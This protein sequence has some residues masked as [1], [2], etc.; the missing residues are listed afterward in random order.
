[1][2]MLTAIRTRERHER[3]AAA[4]SVEGER[5][6]DGHSQRSPLCPKWIDLPRK[7]PKLRGQDIA[8]PVTSGHTEH[9]GAS[10][11]ERLS[12]LPACVCK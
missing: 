1:M 11:K 3:D 4:A 8:T 5:L 9:F 7:K 2:Q 10:V 12:G 6:G